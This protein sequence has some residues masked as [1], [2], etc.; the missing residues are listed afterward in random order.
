MRL[1]LR[2]WLRAFVQD[3]WLSTSQ[4]SPRELWR[5][6]FRR[7]MS[8]SELTTTSAKKGR[9]LTNSLKWP[10]ASE[11]ESIR[12]TS[13]Q[14]ITPLKVMTKEVSLRGHNIPHNLPGNNK[15]PLGHQLQGTEA[16]GASEE[17]LGMSL[18]RFTAYSVV[19]ARAILQECAMSPFRN[20]RK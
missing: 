13:G 17:G 15:A 6:C 14:S 10:G 19:R 11:E 7:W 12:G 1:S 8:I 3:L 20:K 5:N 16:S 2:P 18:E 9:K 4:G